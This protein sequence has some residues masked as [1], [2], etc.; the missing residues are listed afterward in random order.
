[1]NQRYFTAFLIGCMSV[2]VACETGTTP[3]TQS[4]QLAD[5][6]PLAQSLS[7]P[8]APS[9][10][11]PPPSPESLE[12]KGQVMSF[13][14][15]NEEVAQAR[16]AGQA[17]TESPLTVALQFVGAQFDCR[18]KTVAVKSLSGGEVFDKVL[19]T[20]TEDG[21]LDDSVSASKAIIR[22][23]RQNGFWRISSA[24]QVWRCWEGRGHVEYSNAAC[25]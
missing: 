24:R 3:P 21:L 18:E 25:H 11:P 22:M 14:A 1:M 6:T 12:T 23:E 17:W 19:V 4:A 5:S 20:V 16:E 7:S 8:P 13:T 9:S 2:L 15:F 10:P